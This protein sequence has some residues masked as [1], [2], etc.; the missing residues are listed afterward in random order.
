MIYLLLK[1][2][3]TANIKLLWCCNECFI[4]LLLF[5]LNKLFNIFSSILFLFHIVI[6]VM[7]KL[8]LSKLRCV[9]PQVKR[10]MNGVF[11]SL[12]G[13]FDL[14]ET[15][16]GSAVLRVL[17]NTIKVCVSLCSQ[18]DIQTPPAADRHVTVCFPPFTERHTAAPHQT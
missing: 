15:Y 3:I 5:Y 2:Y 12:R 11:Q 9:C 10:V 14:N 18:S 8:T 17:V 7:M 16:S 6:I 4:Y 1:Q 13:E